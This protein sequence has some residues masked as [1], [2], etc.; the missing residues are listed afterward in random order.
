MVEEERAHDRRASERRR[1]VTNQAHHG[2]IVGP[3]TRNILAN[4]LTVMTA[5]HDC[6]LGNRLRGS[7]VTVSGCETG[8]TLSG[9]AR[10][11]RL[12]ARDNVT[13]GIPAKSV[14][15]GDSVVTGNTFLGAPLDMLTRR[16]PLLVNTTR[17]VRE[18][19]L[20]DVVGATWGVC[21]SD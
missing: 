20:R 14:R 13:V 19:L 8:I 15:L 6:I 1:R 4:H 18:Q 7:D 12:D 17:G 21:A 9:T 11:T 5:Q 16:R 2:A 3:G 10:V